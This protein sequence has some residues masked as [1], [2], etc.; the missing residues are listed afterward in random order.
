MIL[1]SAGHHPYRKGAHFG[2]F[3]EYDEAKQWVSLIVNCLGSDG[4]VVP[5]GV[6]KEKIAFINDSTNAVI[7]AEIHFNSAKKDGKHVGRGCET[8]Y[9]PGSKKGKEIANIV[10]R[11]LS[12]VFE[13]DRGVKEGWYQM[14]PEKGPD[15][16][17]KKTKCPSVI[18][19]PEFI[20][21]KEVIQTNRE[22]ACAVIAAALL[23]AN[24]N[25]V[26]EIIA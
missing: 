8:L 13:P 26:Q 4:M 21:H 20:H 12:R 14:N 23:E 5:G 6:L 19:E 9:Y 15:I 22:V 17:L 16:F 7:A 24:N 3:Y 1:I 2:D 18:I 25:I 11:E 10:Q